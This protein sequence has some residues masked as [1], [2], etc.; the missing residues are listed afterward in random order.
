MKT[1]IACIRMLRPYDAMA[2]N[3]FLLFMEIIK[4]CKSSLNFNL[5]MYLNSFFISDKLT[6]LFEN[7]IK[8]FRTI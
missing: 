6:S 2:G 3:F 1:H 4:I 5:S 7:G 8:L